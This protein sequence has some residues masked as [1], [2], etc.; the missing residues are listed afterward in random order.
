M[1]S[2]RI[3]MSPQNMPFCIRI[4][5]SWNQLRRNRH[6]KVSTLPLSTWKQ[7]IKLLLWRY[8]P[9]TTPLSGRREWILSLEIAWVCTNRALLNNL[10]LP[11]ASSNIFTAPKFTT[12]KSL[13]PLFLCLVTSP[14]TYCSLL[15]WYISPYVW[16]FLWIFPILGWRP[17]YAYVINPFSCYSVLC[18]AIL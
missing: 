16:L 5:L 3:R 10:Y 14:Q 8:L 2:K 7:S 4:I 18:Q 12:P 15:K 17:P 6:K 13:N 11:L 9:L 1:I